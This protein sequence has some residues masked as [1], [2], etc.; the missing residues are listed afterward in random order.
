MRPQWIWLQCFAALGA[1]AQETT[2]PSTGTE[3]SASSSSSTQSSSK[4]TS[5]AFTNS[6]SVVTTSLPESQF[7]ESQYTYLTYNSQSVVTGTTTS[8]SETTTGLSGTQSVQTSQHQNVTQISGGSSQTAT[9]TSSAPAVSNTVPCN[10]YPEFCSRKYSNITEVCA[11]NSA[12]D[13]KNNAASNQALGIVDQLDDG[14]RMSM[15]AL[16]ISDE[17]ILTFN[18]PG[19]GSLGQ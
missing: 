7:T 5:F 18:S 6:L 15:L 19:R 9:T 8:S 1:R 4:T 14:V 10:N 17:K 12:F 13:I 2:D 16:P 3:S 11:H